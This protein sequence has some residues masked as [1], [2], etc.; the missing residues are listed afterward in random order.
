MK[1]FKITAAIACAAILTSCVVIQYPPNG[2]S[3]QGNINVS[4]NCPHTEAQNVTAQ[5]QTDTPE[6]EPVK[7]SET[8]AHTEAITEPP[9][10]EAVTEAVETENK[11]NLK[12]IFLI[13]TT[14]PISRNQ[15]ASI[16][17]IGEP[18]TTYTIEVFYATGKSNAK[19]LEPK[20]SSDVGAVSWSWRIGPSLKT[21]RYKIVISGG[22]DSLETEIQIN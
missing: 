10:T 17:I 4:I 16:D 22:G 21:G 15:T 11:P 9:E 14:S 1:L 20:T 6:T 3:G 5:P 18:N 7:P 2:N 8:E 12:S 19:G 13:S